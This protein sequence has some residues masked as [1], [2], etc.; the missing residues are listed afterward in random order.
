V[1]YTKHISVN[2]SRADAICAAVIVGLL[3]L[4]IYGAMLALRGNA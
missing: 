3:G 2:V 1:I 4:T